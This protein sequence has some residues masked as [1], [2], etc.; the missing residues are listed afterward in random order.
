MSRELSLIR[1]SYWATASASLPWRTSR[2]ACWASLLR[3]MAKSLSEPNRGTLSN[4]PECQAV[5]GAGSLPCHGFEMLPRA[6]SLVGRKP[7]TRVFPIVVTH[8]TIAHHLGDDGRGGDRHG[9]PVPLD[10]RGLGDAH[11]GKRDGVDQQVIGSSGKCRD[12]TCHR[13]PRRIEDVELIDFPGVRRALSLI[14]ISE[15]TRLLSI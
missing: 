4:T 14:H 8:Q 9:D 5:N 1:S 7:E 13:Q 11:A 2:S 15:P 10:Q 3:S 6:V 12:R